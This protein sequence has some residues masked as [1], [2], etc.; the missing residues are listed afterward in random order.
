MNRDLES[1]LFATDREDRVNARRSSSIGITI[2]I[3]IRVWHRHY[4]TDAG[5]CG[6]LFLHLLKPVPMN[7]TP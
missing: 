5:D 7:S 3:L 6:T 1:I 4:Y 2:G